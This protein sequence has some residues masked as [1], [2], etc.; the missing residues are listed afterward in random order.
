ML[1]KTRPGEEVRGAS[2][3]WPPIPVSPEQA[4][5]RKEGEYWT[6]G[7]A[8]TQFR[9]KD[10]KGLA[11]VAHLLRY[12]GMKF[13]A[14]DLARGTDFAQPGEH[15]AAT[16]RFNA[17]ELDNAGVHVRNLGGADEMLD[18][19]AKATY[20]GRLVELREELCEAKAHAQIVRAER[21]ERE[22]DALTAELS[23]A[24]GLGGR[25]RCA[26]SASEHAR[27]SV[28]RAI[29]AALSRIAD[30]HEPLAQILSRCIT[31]GTNCYYNPDAN[32]AISWDFDSRNPG[33]AMSSYHEGPIG[34][35]PEQSQDAAVGALPLFWSSSINQ[36]EFVG[37]QRE[38]ELLHGL[39]ERAL[40]GQ[41]SLVMFG[42]G[43]GVGKT[44]L[45]MEGARYAS[46]R[47]CFCNIGHCY[48]S[49][50]AYPYLPFAE[51]LEAT[52]AQ[53]P[54]RDLFRQWMGQY[55][56]EHAQIAPSLRR[57]FPDI[58][59]LPPLPPQQARRHLFQSI[60]EPLKRL[61]DA[62]PLFFVLDDLQW[63]D[64]STL[65]LLNH[66]ANR[67]AQ[68]PAVIIGTYRDVNLPDNP[69]L[70]R[71][72]EELIR[73]GIRP[74]KLQGLSE[75]G[76]AQMLRSL[77]S[78]EPPA[79]LVHVMFEQTLGNP[80]F[81]E[82]IYRHLVEEGKVFAPSGEFHTEFSIAQ[83]GLPDNIRLVLWRR[84]QRLDEKV[85]RVLTAAAAIGPSFRFESLHALHDQTTLDDLLVYLEQA[86]RTG[87]IVSRVDG[88]EATFTFAHDLVRQTL[89]ASI[90]VARRELLHLRAAE[91]SQR[92]HLGPCS[93][94]SLI[95]EPA[96]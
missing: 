87:L 76:V 35:R 54:S 23:R 17:Q 55:A 18:R 66:L 73:I 71:T 58:P 33:E 41:G 6:V 75:N 19:R 22:I 93:S 92:E 90:S 79:Q 44:R 63:A 31:T 27:Q 36:T 12:P 1:W 70:V 42:G 40:G 83:I 77:S 68:I 2:S 86:E 61:A 57:V 59:P 49:E 13:H 85:R 29:R 95:A 89:L 20:C 21:V 28:T 10:T 37:R 65:A 53:A 16:S 32:L 88:Q 82:E 39:V 25:D 43:P 8:G 26:A 64:E 94:A 9:L 48:E 52:L 60:T 96:G 72:L 51:M 15:R 84:L 5:F 46:Q 47:G 11:Y 38:A 3:S 45:A 56:A 91:A 74:L 4:L 62:T 14:L 67:V 24:T 69:A 78:R 7:Y 30:N 34:I 50:E 81:V 80:F